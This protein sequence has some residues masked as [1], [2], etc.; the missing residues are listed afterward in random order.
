MGFFSQGS[1]GSVG[2]SSLR[3]IL[4]R[5]VTEAELLWRSNPM[6]YT[7]VEAWSV[8]GVVLPAETQSL[9]LLSTDS[10]RFVITRDPDALL[11]TI[12]RGLA[13]GHEMLAGFGLGRPDLDSA[14]L[15]TIR[16]IQTERKNK[17]TLRAIAQRCGDERM[18][19]AC[20]KG[21]DW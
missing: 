2:G 17:T 5:T 21:Q 19:N 11:T 4:E 6:R 15:I 1:L 10:C 16:E 12:D 3:F 9:E 7:Y 8:L 20:C 14:L 18:I 13:I